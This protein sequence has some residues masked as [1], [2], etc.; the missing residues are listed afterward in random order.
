ARLMRREKPQIGWFAARTP[1]S[2]IAESLALQ[3][4]TAASPRRFS[5]LGRAFHSS[6]TRGQRH[7]EI[8][9]RFTAGLKRSLLPREVGSKGVRYL[10]GASAPSTCAGAKMGALELNLRPK[11]GLNLTNG[12][13]GRSRWWMEMPRRQIAPRAD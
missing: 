5:T 4:G 8:A 12:V 7:T 10:V 3:S 13:W 6:S 11:G 9:P 1:S 2:A